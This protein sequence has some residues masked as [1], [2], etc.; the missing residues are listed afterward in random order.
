MSW[1]GG[2]F[3][4]GSGG[5]GIG[6]PVITNLYPTP[7]DPIGPAEFLR[8][9]I[10][11]YSGGL[12]VLPVATLDPLQPPELIHDGADFVNGYEGTRA[13]VAGGYRFTVRKQYGWE[14]TPS[15]RVWVGGEAS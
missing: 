4:A 7:G 13:F 8:F 1:S 14:T 5:G 3:G 2:W 12:V 9:D 10:T 15:I 11:G 6:T